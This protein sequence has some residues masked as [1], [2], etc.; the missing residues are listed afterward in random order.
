MQ[1]RFNIGSKMSPVA[2]ER[3]MCWFRVGLLLASC[4]LAFGDLRSVMNNI[5]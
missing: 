1:D 2:T 4:V 5:Y 3:D